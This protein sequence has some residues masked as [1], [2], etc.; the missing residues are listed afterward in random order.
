MSN[1]IEF[2]V[3]TYLAMPTQGVRRKG[4]ERGKRK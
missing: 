3:R 2:C 4:N 1:K